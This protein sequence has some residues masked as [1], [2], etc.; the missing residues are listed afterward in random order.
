MNPKYPI[1]IPSKGRYKSCYTIKNFDEIKVP[2]HIVI[3]KQEYKMYKQYVNKKNIIVVPHQNKGLITTRNWIW[4]FAEKKGYKRFWTFDDNIRKIFR[5]NKNLQI[6][7]G[8]GTVLRCI[9]DFTERYINI[10]ISGM[11]YYHFQPRKRNLPPFYVNTRVYSNML[12]KTDLKDKEG[13]KIRNRA[14]YND[15]TELCLNIMKQGYCT[16]LFNAFLIKKQ[17]TMT[18]KGGMTEYYKNTNKRKE[19]VEELQ[20]YHPE[21]VK[22]TKKWNRY[23]HNVDYSFFRNIYN[24]KLIKKKNL[25][26]KKGIDNYG[27]ELIFLKTK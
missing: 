17:Q 16:I 13:N 24:S 6:P 5:F 18:M 4:D 3:E 11:H 27:M 7:I 2:Y 20:K 26:I 25:K 14:F 12:I 9:E 22:L 23:H 10:G 1:F 15:D 19:F 8:D 21:C